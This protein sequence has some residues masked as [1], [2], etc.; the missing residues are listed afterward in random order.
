LAVDP[1]RADKEDQ[2]G[3]A[4]SVRRVAKAEIRSA[5]EWY[6][7]QSPLVAERFLE[8][9]DAAIAAIEA[10]PE[11]HRIVRGRLRRV[12]LRSFPYGVYFKVFPSLISVVG[13]FHGHRHP[14][15]W[16]RREP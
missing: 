15:T 2:V 3:A 7:K 5:H 8:A 4:A 12:L 13:V 16:L 11:R 1:K 14:R 6:R 10:G 9:V